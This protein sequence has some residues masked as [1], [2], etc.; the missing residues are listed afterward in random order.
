MKTPHN[1]QS[2]SGLQSR[3]DQLDSAPRP[4]I[5]YN[6][7]QANRALDTEKLLWILRNEAPRF[8]HMAEVVGNWVWIRFDDKQPAEVTSALSEFGFHWNRNR[9]VWQHPC[10]AYRPKASSRDPHTTY[11]S[12]FPADGTQA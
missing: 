6:R 12:Y 1:P 11:R 7:R 9:Q 5:D 2:E 10:A 8:F 3:N 4:A